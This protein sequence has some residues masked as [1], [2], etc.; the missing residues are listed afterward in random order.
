MTPAVGVKCW[1]SSP[2][3]G[4]GTWLLF[5]S[6]FTS[7]CL[8]CISGLTCQNGYTFGV[9]GAVRSEDRLGFF[10]HIVGL[11]Y[12][13]S[14][15]GTLFLMPFLNSLGSFQIASEYPLRPL[16]PPSEPINRSA[17]LPKVLA[18]VLPPWEPRDSTLCLQ[19]TLV[20]SFHS[21]WYMFHFT[22]LAT[23]S[24]NWHGRT[25]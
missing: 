7:A 17:S 25:M 9:S 13:W 11:K 6:G 5:V 2:L 3:L 21:V 23:K 1:T 14:G 12:D 8:G 24:C 4:Q 18:L 15:H 16:L 20:Y 10:C 22:D 19:R